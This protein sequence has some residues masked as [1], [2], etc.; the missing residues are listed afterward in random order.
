MARS[1]DEF[2]LAWNALSGREPAEGWRGIEATPAGPCVLHAARR[3]PGNEEAFLA[4]FSAAA[5]VAPLRQRLPEGQGFDVSRPE[6]IADGKT[7]VAIS[8]KPS[9]SISLFAE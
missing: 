9:G 1:I 5:V 4:G 3:F 6:G 8:R 2:V 7:W